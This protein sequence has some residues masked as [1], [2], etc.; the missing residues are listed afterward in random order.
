M[1]VCVK[2]SSVAERLAAKREG[3]DKTYVDLKRPM[4]R[5]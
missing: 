5:H 4:Q 2:G 3:R 1:C